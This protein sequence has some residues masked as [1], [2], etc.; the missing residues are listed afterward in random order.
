MQEL[1]LPLQKAS[2]LGVERPGHILPLVADAVSAFQS[3]HHCTIS[4]AVKSGSGGSGWVGLLTG[5]VRIY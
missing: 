1:C 5:P 2:P 4:V 3:S